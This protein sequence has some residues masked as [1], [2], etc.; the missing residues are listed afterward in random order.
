MIKS[1]YQ[2]GWIGIRASKV[3]RSSKLLKKQG[4]MKLGHADLNNRN[5]FNWVRPVQEEKDFINKNW[6]ELANVGLEGIAIWFTDAQWGADAAVTDVQ[7]QKR[8]IIEADFN[9][10]W[11]TGRRD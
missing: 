3:G 1:K 4:W 7:W 5:G 6:S 8:A 9:S 10:K 2:M 11:P